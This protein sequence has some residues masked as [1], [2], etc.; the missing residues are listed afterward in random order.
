MLSACDMTASLD[1]AA[2]GQADIAMHFFVEEQILQGEKIACKDL[3]QGLVSDFV[4]FEDGAVKETSNADGLTCDVSQHVDVNELKWDGADHRPL[5]EADDAK[6][7]Y[8][9]VLPFSEGTGSGELQLSDF[10]RLGFTPDVSMTVTMPQPIAST[11][12]GESEGN[13]VTLSGIDQFV[14]DVDIVADKQGPAGSR[15]AV[16]IGF[17]AVASVV[18]GVAAWVLHRRQRPRQ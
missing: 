12:V 17:V 10:E 15:V 11:S 5:W 3:M 16:I 7:R 9:L 18:C 1:I 14:T 2:D 13:T 8:H 4:T 6:G